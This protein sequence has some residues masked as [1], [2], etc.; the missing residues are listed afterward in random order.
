MN[1]CKVK[2]RKRIPLLNS[3]FDPVTTEETVEW[4]IRLIK[5]GQRGYICTVNVAILMMMRSNARLAKFIEEA[6]LVVADGQP[7]V[8]TSRLLSLPLPQRVAGVDLIDRLAATSQKEGLK[9]YLLGATTDVIT[10]AA[11]NLQY[12]YPQLKICGVDNGYFSFGQAGERVEAIR[13]SGAQILFVGMGVPRQEFFLEENWSKLGVNLAIGVGGSFEIFAGTK[14]RA[15][16]WVQEVG[17]EWFYRLL[18]EPGR[19]WKRYFLT[20]SQ[21]IYELLRAL[22]YR[23]YSKDGIETRRIKNS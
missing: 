3:S 17:L 1:N 19:L 7:I 15:P 6:A 9:I 11:L 20:N 10:Q 23:M 21:F 22:I 18:Q 4:A 2:V 14:K 8:W 16:L 13:R 12:K 5:E